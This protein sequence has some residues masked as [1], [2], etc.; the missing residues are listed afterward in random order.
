LEPEI[1]KALRI[2]GA[3]ADQDPSVILSSLILEHMP[4]EVREILMTSGTELPRISGSFFSRKKKKTRQPLYK[5][6]EALAIVDEMLKRYP[7]VTY[8][9][10]GDAVGYGRHTIGN[11]HRQKKSVPPA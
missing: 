10:I 8:K 11:Y 4:P 7:E 9:D 1:L 3:L 6:L 5:N 2:W